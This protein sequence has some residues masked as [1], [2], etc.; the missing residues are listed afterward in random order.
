[1]LLIAQ[2]N[3]PSGGLPLVCYWYPDSL[4]GGGGG[5]VV[6]KIIF[7]KKNYPAPTCVFFKKLK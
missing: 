4:Y 3:T 7:I 2:D 5:G 1:L 6:K